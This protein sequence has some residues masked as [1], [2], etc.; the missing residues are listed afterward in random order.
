MSMF[1][2][3]WGSATAA[4]RYNEASRACPECGH[5]NPEFPEHLWGWRRWVTQ[6]RSVNAA[7]LA[8]AAAAATDAASVAR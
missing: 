2:T 8:L 4:D 6:Q 7:K 3:L 5:L 1:P